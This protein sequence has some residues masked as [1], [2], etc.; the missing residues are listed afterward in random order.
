MESQFNRENQI[1]YYMTKIIKKTFQQDNNFLKKYEMFRENRSVPID[2]S[3]DKMK[4]LYGWGY[5]KG[6]LLNEL[7][8]WIYLRPDVSKDLDNGVFLSNDLI[9]KL[10][11][12]KHYFLVEKKAI[13]F[14]KLNCASISTEEEHENND[15]SSETDSSVDYQAL[16]RHKKI[17]G[18]DDEAKEA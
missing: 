18:V 2:I 17:F 15:E 11:L 3:W 12:N 14:L 7:V 13:A 8:T 9:K 4:T 10:V 1:E 6:S 16:K 5:R